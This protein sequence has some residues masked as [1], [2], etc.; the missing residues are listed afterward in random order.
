[1]N[2]LYLCCFFL[3]HLYFSE[4]EGRFLHFLNHHDIL[5]INVRSVNTFS[6]PIVLKD[7]HGSKLVYFM[8]SDCK[9]CKEFEDTF[10]NLAL[11]LRRWKHFIKFLIFDCAQHLDMLTCSEYGIPQE[12]TLRFF[13]MGTSK[14]LGLD[15]K[16][17]DIEEITSLLA[18]KLSQLKYVNNLPNFQ[19]LQQGDNITTIFEV[20]IHVRSIALV[21]QPKNSTVARDT[22]LNLSEYP[23]L[24]VR[25]LKDHRILSNFGLKP[26]HQKVVILH[27][28]GEPESLSPSEDT[29]LAYAY[30]IRKT[31]YRNMYTSNINK[32]R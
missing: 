15:I 31:V 23:I 21:Y 9:R 8:D 28:D 7:F 17:R 11:I 27:R 2:L 29:S 26:A 14:G 24:Q 6:L 19:P 1:M 20:P 12:P 18:L 10:K 13:P 16:S 25:I 30:L 22:I 32:K 3:F 5:S 4:V